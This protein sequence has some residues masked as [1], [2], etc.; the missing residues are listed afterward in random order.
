FQEYRSK[1]MEKKGWGIT[2]LYNQYYH[3]TASLL[4]QYHQKIDEL[5]LK[6]YNF[7]PDENI[8]EKLF[9]LNQ[10]LAEKSQKS[11]E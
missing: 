5:V 8:L 7:L 3:E 10:E 2:Q 11:S 4:Y 9:Q 6:A 1:E